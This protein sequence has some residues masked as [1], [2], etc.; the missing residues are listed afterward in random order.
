MTV[1]MIYLQDGFMNKIHL[2]IK[3]LIDLNM[4]NEQFLNRS[5]Y[6]LQ[7]TVVISQQTEIVLE[8]VINI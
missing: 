6:N 5:M 3:K 7:V 8:N 1:K 4:V 2:N